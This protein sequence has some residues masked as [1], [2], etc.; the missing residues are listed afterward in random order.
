MITLYDMSLSGNCHKVRLLLGLLVLPYQIQA[1]DLRGGEQRSPEHLQRNPFGQVPVLDDEGL[2]IRDS[3]AI[4]VYLA[5]RY[6]GE[7]WWPDDAYQ[8]AQIA[9]WLSTAANEVANGPAKLRVHHKF[10]SPIDTAAAGHT[11]DKVLGIIDRHLQ[12]QDWL[13]GDSV[14]IA[15]IA[16]YPYLALAPEGGLDIE[17]YSNTL[18]WFQR[19][20]ALP[21]YVAMPGMWQA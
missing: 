12:N 18:A 6:G 13:V 1:V 15:D 9:A 14:S 21:G 8:L 2:I 16:V 7:K 11:A 3:Q 4:L 19:L 5:K 17:T 20:R 10:G